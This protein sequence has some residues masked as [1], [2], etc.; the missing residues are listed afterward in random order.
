ML[1]SIREIFDIIGI[2]FESIG[3]DF[4]E[5]T[6]F[7]QLVEAL[8]VG[9]CPVVSVHNSYWNP[10]SKDGSHAMV[11]TGIK[12]KRGV[13]FIQLKN[14]HAD[15][16]NEPGKVQWFELI[17]ILIWVN[18]IFLKFYKDIIDLPYNYTLEMEMFYIDFE[19]NMADPPVL[20][21]KGF[22]INALIFH[23]I[24][25]RKPLRQLSTL[26]NLSDDL[27]SALNDIQND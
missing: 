22:A 6:E 5:F 19:F 7:K 1:D 13:Q 23:I 2:R 8:K 11:A 24:K 15:N 17:E 21:Q 16:P 14:S 9:K 20:K 27:K 12:H 4:D 18:G 3:F 10:A 26:F 25:V